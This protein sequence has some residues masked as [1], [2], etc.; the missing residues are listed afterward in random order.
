MLLVV[1]RDTHLVHSAVLEKVGVLKNGSRCHVPLLHRSSVEQRPQAPC[2]Y[3][4]SFH[5]QP[6]FRVSGSKLFD[7]LM[8]G[9][10]M[11]AGT[12]PP[13]NAKDWREITETTCLCSRL[14]ILER[15]CLSR[16]H[17]G[18]EPP[19]HAQLLRMHSVGKLYWLTF[20]HTHTHTF[21]VSLYPQS[22]LSLPT[23]PR[24]AISFPSFVFPLA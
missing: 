19:R 11:V 16:T 22:P 14:P 18:K 15:R 9:T 4:R 5:L 7:V 21:P 13:K 20:L 23:T 24:Q 12:Q 1:G 3:I 2:E 17:T 10:R 8:G 6:V